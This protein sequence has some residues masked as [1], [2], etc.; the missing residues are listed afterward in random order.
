MK[1]SWFAVG[2][3]VGLVAVAFTTLPERVGRWF[4][5]ERAPARV[6]SQ[7]APKADLEFTLKDMN[8]RDVRLAD[9][10]GHVV[11]LNFWATWCGPC[12]METPWLVELQEKYRSQGFRVI[13]ISVD[14][15]PEALPPFAR[16]FKVN[17]PL[18]LGR[19]RD[20]VQKAFGP[21]FA[22]PM[23]VIIGRDGTM[24]V[25]HIGPVAKE[26]FESEIRAL[27]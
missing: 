1:K 19:D 23:T 5:G 4:S 2:V 7:D 10:K 21:V 18:A 16:E 26:Q 13:G 25:K 6:C 14:D 11:L 20:D 27:L 22:L 17:Y 9:L 24:C 15:P 3:G 12:R 8:G